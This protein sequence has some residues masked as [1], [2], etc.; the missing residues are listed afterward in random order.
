L[1]NDRYKEEEMMDQDAIKATGISPEITGI[2]QAET[3]GQAE[4]MRE[5]LLK[6]IRLQMSYNYEEGMT[7]LGRLRV[8]NIK[9][10]Y[11]QPLRVRK[12]MGED[13]AEAVVKEYRKIPL[14]DKALAIS[15]ETGEYYLQDH[16][17]FDFFQT[18]PDLFR[19]SNIE[20]YY[21]F[22]VKVDPQSSVKTSK[23]L[24]RENEDKFF[25]TYRGDPDINQRTLKT[26]HIKSR[27]KNPDELLMKDR[28]TAPPLP[29]DGG[30]TPSPGGPPPSGGR[31]SP[32]S[33]L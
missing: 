32:R 30:G 31:P 23:L 12:I 13:G 5:S 7:R 20:R 11:Q 26:D 19:D 29:Q 9:Q 16:E 27:D 24:E 17:G 10:F 1:K 15:E 3:L 4:M 2:P 25:E 33:R 8:S 28:G 22:D 18:I 6:R 14:R 21:E